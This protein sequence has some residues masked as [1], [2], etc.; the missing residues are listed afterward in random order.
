M[1]LQLKPAVKGLITAL[2]MIVAALIIDQTGNTNPRF[3][4]FVYLIY[5]TGIFWTLYAKSRQEDTI[6]SFKEYFSTGF[7]CFIIITLL[8]VV[9]TIIFLKMHPEFLEQE[10]IATKEYYIQKGGKTPAE[11]EE[12]ANMAKKRYPV[13]VISLSIFRYLLIGTGF[14][15][16]FSLLFTRR[17]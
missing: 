15:V 16:F 6:G 1:Q 10:A 2:L 11:M 17:K 5:G 8:M 7:R 13:L 9:F 14:T 3:Q 12:L 4:Y